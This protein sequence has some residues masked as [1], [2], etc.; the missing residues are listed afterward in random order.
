MRD[1]YQ[2]L[3]DNYNYCNNPK[4]RIIA[5]IKLFDKWIAGNIVDLGCGRGL[6]V[7][8]LINFGYNVIGIDFIN[9][10]EMLKKDITK[11]LNL[12]LF[13]VSICLDVFEHLT[14]I[15]VIQVLKNMQTTKRQVIHVNNKPCKLIGKNLHINI[16]SFEEWYLLINKYLKIC[17]SPY[18]HEIKSIF[19]CK[20]K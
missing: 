11:P 18:N 9:F 8:E 7:K 3:Y 2:D 4:G 10:K 16:K 6:Y 19:F 13:D 20:Q 5:T 12:S 1:I 15:E 14:D 17:K